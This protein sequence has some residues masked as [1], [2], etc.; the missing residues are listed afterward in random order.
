MN[1]GKSVSLFLIDGTINGRLKC[2]IANW[3]GIGFKIP[4]TQLGNCKDRPELKQTGIYLLMGKSDDT[5]DEMVYVGQASIRK[6][7][8]GLIGRLQEHNKN[9]EKD[10][11]NEAIVITTSNDSLSGTEIGYLE[12]RLYTMAKNAKR[13]IVKNENAPACG[14]ITEEKRCELED[15]I[16]YTRIVVAALGHKVFEPI[17]EMDEDADILYCKRSGTNA[18]G[19]LTSDGFV[20]FKNSVLSASFTK[21]CPSYIK[22]KRKKLSYIIGTDNTLVEDILFNSPSTASSFVCGAST[23]GM[24]EW[25]NKDGKTLKDLSI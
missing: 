13:Y 21:S 14:N 9:L 6:N 12:N 23:N 1:R 10:Y 15:F 25:V 18:K 20:V 5:T 2:S 11:W 8:Q 19:K 22:I 4:R 7:G 3:T 16:D 17:A 24:V